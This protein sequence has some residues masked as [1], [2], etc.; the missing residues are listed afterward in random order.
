MR[1]VFL[2]PP[3]VYRRGLGG[4]RSNGSV[5]V[6]PLRRVSSLAEI[7]I[8]R[9][10]GLSVNHFCLIA[11][12]ICWAFCTAK[13]FFADLA[14]V[15]VFPTNFYNLL[16]INFLFKGGGSSF[17]KV[18]YPPTVMLERLIPRPLSVCLL[19]LLLA[20]LLSKQQISNVD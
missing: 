18:G 19:P 16:I 4:G 17:L 2:I 7:D 11:F 20:Y 12:Q 8:I 1:F 5:M 10:V 14:N 15:G 9:M 13:C 3:P 6:T